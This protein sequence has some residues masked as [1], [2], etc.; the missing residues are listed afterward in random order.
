M[1]TARDEEVGRAPAPEGLRCLVRPPATYLFQRSRTS[2]VPAE[3]KK[4]APDR[5]VS[6]FL[7]GFFAPFYPARLPR[8]QLLL[9]FR[10]ARTDSSGSA[11]LAASDRG[12]FAFSPSP[13]DLVLVPLRYLRRYWR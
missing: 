7:A 10:S 4:G 1:V 6:A 3:G 12:N 9:A 2:A 13:L 8:L 11:H 5:L